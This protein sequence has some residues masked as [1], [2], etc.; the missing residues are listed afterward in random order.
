MLISTVIVFFI[1]YFILNRI[2]IKYGLYDKNE[3][4]KNH[5]IKIPLIG[6]ACI[7][8]TLII[9]SSFFS[10]KDDAH[11]MILLSF[12]IF[13]MG[14]L[15]DSLNLNFKLR[16]LIQILFVLFYVIFFNLIITNYGLITINKDFILISLFV[17][18][19][20]IVGVVN[21]FNFIDG[22]DGLTSSLFLVAII[23]IKIFVFLNT[24]NYFFDELDVLL[25]S[26]F[27][28]LLINKQ[29]IKVGKIYLGDSGSM[30]LGFIVSIYLIYYSNEYSYIPPSIVPWFIAVPIFDFFAVIFIRIL[31]KKNPMVGDNQHLHHVLLSKGYSDNFVLIFLI[32]LSFL[33]CFFGILVNNFTNDI[34][35]IVLFICV[36]ILYFFYRIKDIRK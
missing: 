16:F 10:I 23:F 15:D 13:I 5:L 27:C 9:I 34:I 18:I 2:A 3:Y 33:F 25:V 12:G 24:G 28:F 22:L 17:T 36:L 29:I 8:F 35:S 21:A 31:N 11:L 20:S 1:L 19:F 7:F 32:S 30:F 26:V 14:F 4:K 6:G